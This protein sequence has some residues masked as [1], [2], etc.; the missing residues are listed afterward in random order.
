MIHRVSILSSMK[1][2]IIMGLSHGF[3]PL[4]DTLQMPSSSDVAG[5]EYM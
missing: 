1:L 3:S 5:W 2:K 4:E